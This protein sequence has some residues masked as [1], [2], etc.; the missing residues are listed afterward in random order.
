MAHFEQS[1][2]FLAKWLANNITAQELEAFKK[3]KDYELFSKIA[4]ESEGFSRAQINK[5]EVYNSILQKIETKKNAKIKPLFPKWVTAV[6]ASIVL[7]ISLVY[8]LPTNTT[9]TSGFGE[10]L[11][12]MLPDSSEVI[13]NS[14]TKLS[15][16]KNNWNKNR[17]L[18]LEGEA[19]F[20]VTKGSTFTV[21]TSE[22]QIA[23]L[24][25]QFSVLQDNGFL[26]VKCFEGKV[27]VE[28]HG[29]IVYLTQGKV[30]KYFNGT[31]YNE[32]KIIAQT[33][34]SWINGE[35]TFKSVPLKV[36]FKSLE[37]Q[38]NITIKNDK[39]DDSKLFTGSFVHSNI[40]QALEAVML[41]MQIKYE[42]FSDKKEVVLTE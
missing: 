1:E 31:D 11:A 14:K 40:S 34:P 19:Y 42:L 37:K 2:T 26:L 10:Q 3:T 27:K 4:F 6:A 30:Y 39:I 16:N 12:I 33:K 22:G 41:P 35:S 17:T 20:K 29:N 24:G 25:T 38:Y 36:V 5:S 9:S 32:E 28:S 15:Y 7:L 13:L 18:N 21:E 8:F 23:V